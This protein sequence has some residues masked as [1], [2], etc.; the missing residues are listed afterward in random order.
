MCDRVRGRVHEEQVPHAH[1]HKQKEQCL[2]G[3]MQK[4]KRERF[5]DENSDTPKLFFKPVRPLT[6]EELNQAVSMKDSD[7][8]IK[9]ITLTVSQTDKVETK[10]NGS[11]AKQEP[12]L[13]D[14][15]EP[16]KVAKKKEVTAPSP[17]EA[18]LASIVDNWDD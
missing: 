7:D 3:T 16:K 14:A 17:D 10:R 1:R 9:A 2:S 8:A 12:V 11:V 6:E 4:S 5:R 13:D 15:P 18:D